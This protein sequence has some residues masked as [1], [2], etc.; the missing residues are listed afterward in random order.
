MNSRLEEHSHPKVNKFLDLYGRKIPHEKDIG[1]VHRIDRRVRGNEV[2]KR[3][4]LFEGSQL[5]CPRGFRRPSPMKP[6]WHGWKATTTSRWVENCPWRFRKSRRTAIS[7]Y[8]T[9]CGCFSSRPTGRPRS[10]SSAPPKGSP[11][12][13]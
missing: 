1:F 11:A 3:K 4:C 7:R 13:W 12:V 5:G 10:R 2:V 8:G 9:T 6:P